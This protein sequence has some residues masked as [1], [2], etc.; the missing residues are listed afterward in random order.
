MNSQSPDEEV[1][2]TFMYGKDYEHEKRFWILIIVVFNIFLGT[3]I[4][5]NILYGEIGI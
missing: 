5:N 2:N 1:Y 3:F 4:Y